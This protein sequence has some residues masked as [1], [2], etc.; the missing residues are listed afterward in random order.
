MASSRN[1]IGGLGG[2]ALEWDGSDMVDGKDSERPRGQENAAQRRARQAAELRA[3]LAKR[4]ALARA[5]EQL[6]TI[7]APDS[8]P[9][10][11]P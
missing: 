8:D 6:E 3:N 1:A 9:T 11:D 4:K 10:G 2:G 7:K 5:R